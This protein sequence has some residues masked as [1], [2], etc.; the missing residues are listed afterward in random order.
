MKSDLLAAKQVAAQDTEQVSRDE[1]II[2]FCVEPKTRDEIQTYVGIAHREYFRAYILK[3][4]LK[5][6]KL[7]MTIPDKPNSRNQKYIKA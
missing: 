1:S 3:L 7:K 5:S 6:G 2:E 4:L